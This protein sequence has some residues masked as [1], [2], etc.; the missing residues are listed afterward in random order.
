MTHADPKK[1]FVVMPFGRKPVR[2]GS[3]RHYDFD[4]VYRV[5]IRRAIKGAGLEPIRADEHKG[6]AII[7][8]DM[9]KDLRDHDVVLADLSLENANVFYELGIRHV[10][11]PRGTVLMCHSDTVLPFDVHLS[12]VIKYRYDG[13]S[14]DWEE[15]ERVVEE[16]RLALE[17]AKRGT[18]DSPVH[19]L[20]ETVLR[21]QESPHLAETDGEPEEQ[22]H[23]LAAY[24]RLVAEHWGQQGRKLAELRSEHSDSVFG[25]RA[26][27][28]LCLQANETRPEAT[29]VAASLYGYEQY[30]LA[31]E[32]YERLESTLDWNELLLY[33]SA[34]SERQMD[35]P[36]ANRGMKLLERAL[37]AARAGTE[38]VAR[39][40]STLAGLTEWIWRL[41]QNA[42]DLEAAIARLEQARQ[43]WEGLADGVT[44]HVGRLALVHL[45]LL[46]LLRIRDRNRERSDSE[47]HREAI[48]QLKPGRALRPVDASY[49]RWYKAIVLA[50]G[51]DG[52]GAH[53]LAV[54]ALR[55]DTKLRGRPDSSDIGRRQYSHLR[56]LIEHYSPVLQ[57]P[58]HV[59]RISQM[60][61]VGR[62]ERA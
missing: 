25:V 22:E 23:P 51:G 52:D 11:A 4:K 29:R 28:Y 26:L 53:R 60:L 15:T 41:T 1:C 18:P 46:L 35:L 55:E 16:L 61:H 57:H 47:R 32:I 34:V 33:G 13:E 38:E 36:A 10:M 7:H 43:S 9:F 49:L 42:A 17:E 2:D 8:T 19:A 54:T 30:D 59:G 58:T 31:I 62:D 3:G 44:C 21:H 20:L 5:V 24:Q 50:D 12:R 14:L 48:L 27:G 37:E 6:S 45:K 39:C 56:R 40:H